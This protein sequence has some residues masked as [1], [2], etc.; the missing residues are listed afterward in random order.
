MLLEA[1][2]NRM[3]L[4]DVATLPGYQEITG[5]IQLFQNMSDAEC[6]SESRDL[7]KAFAYSRLRLTLTDEILRED[8][9]KR[10]KA[11]EYDPI[12]DEDFDGD[13]L[14]YRHYE[15]DQLG[16][17]ADRV[18]GWRFRRQMRTILL[19]ALS[20]FQP[21][22]EQQTAPSPPPRTNFSFVA[23]KHVQTL[24][25][26]RW[27]EAWQC[28]SLGLLLPASVVLGS[29]LEGVLV[30]YFETLADQATRDKYELKGKSDFWNLKRLVEAIV[31]E[32]GF[33]TGVPE[34]TNQIREE[35][36]YIHPNASL[37]GAPLTIEGLQTN[38]YI[39]SELLSHL[40]RHVAKVTP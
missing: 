19:D 39:I 21:V 34:L 9:I 7:A 27:N 30:Y 20:Q 25:Q 29:V 16:A 31:T 28:A 13:Q 35:R 38:F 18:L 2:T 1:L 14:L 22:T 4:S 6:A 8:I 37:K 40:A 24:L 11:V 33:R 17:Q 5:L 15:S 3:K 23:D 26:E 36:N 32:V 10:L 12:I